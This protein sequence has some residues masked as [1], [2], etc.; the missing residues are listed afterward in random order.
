M[1]SL[2][3]CSLPLIT[4]WVLILKGAGKTQIFLD[5]GN[6]KYKCKRFAV[7][8]GGES[9]E[10]RASVWRRKV[11]SNEVDGGE[12]RVDESGR[13]PSSSSGG[14]KEAGG[15]FIYFI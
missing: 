14:R 15:R 8:G 2:S 7:T 1:D 9:L 11:R 3:T 13:H 6:I 10:G 12:A 5:K 4:P